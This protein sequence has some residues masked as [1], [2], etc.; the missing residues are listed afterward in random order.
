MI[1]SVIV[2]QKIYEGDMSEEWMMMGL[3]DAI[4]SSGGWVL[5]AEVDD[6]G[7]PFVWAA[8]RVYKSHASSGTF[9]PIHTC[10]P[11]PQYQM[12]MRWDAVD[13]GG[14]GA[15]FWRVGTSIKSIMT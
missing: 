12:K 4:I 1:Q 6:G 13:D 15:R 8:H 7:P 10:S 14:R 9:H 3:T 2:I 5:K 11:V